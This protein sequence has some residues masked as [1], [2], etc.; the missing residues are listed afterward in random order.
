MVEVELCTVRPPSP[1][2]P[3]PPG[4][5]EDASSDDDD[6]RGRFL[7]DGEYNDDEL[8]FR[9]ATAAETASAAASVGE[10]IIGTISI[11]ISPSSS[12]FL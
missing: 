8:L 10:D 6:E 1:P 3:L 4:K 9:D 12:L 2:P 11:S 5:C 7:L